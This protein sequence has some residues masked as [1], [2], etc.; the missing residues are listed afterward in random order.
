MILLAISIVDNGNVRRLLRI[1]I[2]DIYDFKSNFKQNFL[3][4]YIKADDL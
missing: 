2:L 3:G 1:I 4:Y